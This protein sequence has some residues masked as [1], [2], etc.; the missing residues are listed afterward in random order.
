[1]ENTVAFNLLSG[2]SFFSSSTKSNNFKKLINYKIIYTYTYLFIVFEFSLGRK[3]TTTVEKLQKILEKQKKLT[4][5][6]LCAY[7][8][9]T[10]CPGSIMSII[11]ESVNSFRNIK[12]DDVC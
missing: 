8:T 4:I 7:E 1:M 2:N 3:W 5:R 12:P 9:Y 11:S 6:T 10:C